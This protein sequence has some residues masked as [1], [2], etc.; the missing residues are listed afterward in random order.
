METAVRKSIGVDSGFVA[1]TAASTLTGGTSATTPLAGLF[2]TVKDMGVSMSGPSKSMSIASDDGNSRR[3]DLIEKQMES[4]Q[5][6]LENLQ[7]PDKSR[8]VEI[9]GIPFFDEDDDRVPA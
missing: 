4:M 3:I 8:G 2:K 1:P 7:R 9:G 5:R 6:L